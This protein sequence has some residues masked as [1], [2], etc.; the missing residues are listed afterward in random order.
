M[1]QMNYEQI[2]NVGGWLGEG[3]TNFMDSFKNFVNSRAWD[4]ASRIRGNSESN[5]IGYY[6]IGVATSVEMLQASQGFMRDYIMA[7]PGVME[8]YQEGDISGWEGQFSDW[9]SGTGEDN[10]YYRRQMHGLLQ[11]EEVEDKNVAFTKHYYD[12]VAGTGLS[13]RERYDLALTRTAVNHH[14]AGNLFD[15]TNADGELRK[16]AQ[17]KEAEGG[18]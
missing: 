12:S 4:L 16:S 17:E 11:L 3:A 10:I 2:Q 6:D 1:I 7:M 8:L 9:C 15:I 13:V 5:Y 14:L 18:E